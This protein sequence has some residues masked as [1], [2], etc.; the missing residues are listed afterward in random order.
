MNHFTAKELV[1]LEEHVPENDCCVIPKNLW[2][3]WTQE[4]DIGGILLVKVHCDS[5]EHILYV[6]SFHNHE[7]STIYIPIWCFMNQMTLEVTMER[8][9]EIPPIATKIVLQPLDTELYHCDVTTA[10]S[11]HLSQWQTLTEGTTF[12]VLCAELGGFPVDIFVQK[13]E[14][15][16]T[17][18][19][20]GEVPFELAEPLETI[21]EWEPPTNTTTNTIKRPLTPIPEQIPFLTTFEP[22]G[23]GFIPFSGKGYSLKD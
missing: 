21:V 14:P 15:E 11:E 19:L 20:R 10:I 18:L 13:T 16:S 22:T 5:K 4:E 7:E 23:S 17:V 8:C 1:F 9:T 12:T 2:S 6:Y 3:L